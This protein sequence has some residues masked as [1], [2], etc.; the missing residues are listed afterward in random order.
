MSYS[1]PVPW[2]GVYRP[3]SRWR[4]LEQYKTCEFDPGRIATSAKTES[5]ERC[6]GVMKLFS[7][8]TINKWGRIRDARSTESTLGFHVVH[9]VR[10][11]V[12]AEARG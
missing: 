7:T 10:L 5:E 6:P 2:H 8:I 1:Y 4:A 3:V 12:V 11:D 9:R